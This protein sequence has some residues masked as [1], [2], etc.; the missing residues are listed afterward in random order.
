MTQADR[1][2]WDAKYQQTTASH[3]IDPP[4]W[5]TSA[6]A[7][8]TPG[9]ALDVACGRGQL[10]IWLAEQ[11]WRVTAVDVSPAGLEQ[12]RR[13]AEA[14]GVEVE[15]QLADLDDCDLG[16]EKYELITVFR[17]LDRGTLPARLVAA[18]RNGGTLVYETFSGGGQDSAHVHNPDFVLQPGE[19]RNLFASLSVEVEEIVMVDGEILGRFVARKSIPL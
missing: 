7:G 3:P 17:F 9:R 19:L 4:P 12:A 13:V 11:G 18:L 8:L 16:L 6:I 2:K 14:R 5:F 10:A 1:T 15:W